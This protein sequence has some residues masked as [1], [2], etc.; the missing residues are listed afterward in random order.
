MRHYAK[1]KSPFQADGAVVDDQDNV[2][3]PRS[4]TAQFKNR[5]WDVFG[6]TGKLR[7]TVLL[8]NGRRLMAVTAAHLYI[9]YTDSDGLQWLERYTR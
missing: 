6:S 5:R 7:G 8:P 1:L 9:R 4:E 3:V 2:W